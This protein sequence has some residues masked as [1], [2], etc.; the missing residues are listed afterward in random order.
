VRLWHK[1]LI[2]VLPQKQLVAQWRECCAILSNIAKKGT[3]NHILVNYILSYSLDE[4]RAYTNEVIR[5]MRHRGYKVSSVSVKNFNENKKEAYKY[6]HNDFKTSELYDF[7]HNDRYFWQ[8][9][10]NL[11]EKYDRGMFSEQEWKLIEEEGKQHGKA[12]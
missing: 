5:E 12:N 11:Q 4:F 6:F 7:I 9:Y 2:K 1:D 8:C 3:P 10:F